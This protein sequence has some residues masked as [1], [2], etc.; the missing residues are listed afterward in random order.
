MITFM[1]IFENKDYKI[2]RTK[3]QRT[4]KT[5]DDVLIVFR[6]NYVKPETQATPIHKCHKLT[7]D[8]NTRSLSDFLEELNECDERAFGD[9]TQHMINS[10]LHI[11]LPLDY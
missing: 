6:R 1:H 3:V 4:K 9:N 5:L 8:C 7:I 2:S 11:K 10:L